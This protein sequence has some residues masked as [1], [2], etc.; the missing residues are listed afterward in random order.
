MNDLL[1]ESAAKK[2]GSLLERNSVDLSVPG[3]R[4]HVAGQILADIDAYCQKTYDGGHRKHLGASL[5]GHECERYLYNVF[6]WM[7]H[8][9]FSGRMLRLFNRGHR[10]EERFVEW[11]RGIGF[12]VWEV[13]AEGNQFRVKACHG[14]FGGSLDGVNQAPERYRINE[15]MLLEF[16]TMGT[17]A[18]FTALKAKGVAM[19]KPQHFAQMSTYG[20]FY[21]FKYALY[22]CINKNDD[23]IHVEIVELNWNVGE[24]LLRKAESVIL[25]QTPPPRI[26]ENEAFL[27]CKYCPFVGICHRGE[28]PERNCRSCSFAR[29]A[30]NG[31]WYCG[32]HNAVIPSEFIPNACDAYRAL[33]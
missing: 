2:D 30:E 31:E 22:M 9:K 4:S 5:I 15:P 16:K 21:G 33:T 12:Q 19:C 18:G 14:H 28:A 10:E 20:K 26:A 8:E 29:P 32:N 17:G 6:R 23:D 13:D 1:S 25:A 11:L 7:K 27:S 3:V 24:D